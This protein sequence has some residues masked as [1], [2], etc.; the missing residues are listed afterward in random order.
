M[1]AIWKAVEPYPFV[2]A[3]GPWPDRQILTKAREIVFDG[4]KAF[5]AQEG[6]DAEKDYGLHLTNGV[7]DPSWTRLVRFIP[8]NGS[9][10]LLGEPVDP[11]LDIGAATYSGKSFEVDVYSGPSILEAGKKTGERLPVKKILSPLSISE[12]GAI[13]GIALNFHSHAKSSGLVGLF[14]LF[15]RAV[16][17]LVQVIPKEPMMFMKPE[18]ALADPFPAPTVIPRSTIADDSCD[19][20]SELAVIIGKPCKNVNEKEA[21][22]YVLCVTACNDISS[23]KIQWEQ[24]QVLPT[25][26]SF[27][28]QD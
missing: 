15:V 6:G 1:A 20:E 28:S 23:R 24:K 18:C 17:R 7:K 13:R 27:T 25:S 4:V 11:N 12:V 26:L 21:L 9:R 8:E 2:D 19:Y 14:R 3:F 5:I 16:L 10:I 22:D